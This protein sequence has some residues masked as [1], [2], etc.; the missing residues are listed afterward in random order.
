MKYVG[1]LTITQP[2]MNI[3][4]INGVNDSSDLLYDLHIDSLAQYCQLWVLMIMR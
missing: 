1:K 4:S 3:Y 2:L